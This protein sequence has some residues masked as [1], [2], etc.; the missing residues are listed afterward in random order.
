VTS[1]FHGF[2]IFIAL[3]FYFFGVRKEGFTSLL[4]VEFLPL[5]GF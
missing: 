3:G 2:D 5:L 1:L 4:V